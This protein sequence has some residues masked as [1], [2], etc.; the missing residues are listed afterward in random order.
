MEQESECK[1]SDSSIYE[2][3][4]NELETNQMTINPETNEIERPIF[5]SD[6]LNYEPE[7]YSKNNKTK[8]EKIICI[9]MKNNNKLYIEYEDNWTIKQ[10]YYLK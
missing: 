8:E 6:D 7:T 10:V 5:T 4:E 1:S 2:S 3:F 9:E